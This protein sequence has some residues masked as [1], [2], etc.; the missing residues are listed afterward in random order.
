[1]QMLRVKRA[2][3]AIPQLIS[4]RNVGQLNVTSVVQFGQIHQRLVNIILSTVDSNIK[5]NSATEMLNIV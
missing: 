4:Y 1:M 5:T 3:T 2:T